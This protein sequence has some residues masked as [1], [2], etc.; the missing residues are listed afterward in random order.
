MAPARPW[1]IIRI[2]FKAIT[3]INGNLFAGKIFSC[4]VFNQDETKANLRHPAFYYF[5]WHCLALGLLEGE[6]RADF[7]SECSD[8][9]GCT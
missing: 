9:D 2:S 7:S 6:E 8:G 4:E 3:C 5:S 1:P